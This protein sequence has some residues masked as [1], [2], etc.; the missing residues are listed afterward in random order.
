MF[1]EDSRRGF[2]TFFQKWPW[3]KIRPMGPWRSIKFIG[4]A[5]KNKIIDKT[6]SIASK[7]HKKQAT[8]ECSF[9]A[10]VNINIWE[11]SV[12]PW[13]SSVHNLQAEFCERK[14]YIPRF[15]YVKYQ[16]SVSRRRNETDLTSL[17]SSW[18]ELI[19]ALK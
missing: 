11:K 4:H 2:L 14:L 19:C 9:S 18:Y 17:F 15:F 13:M 8:Y 16:I 5:I 7:Y 12:K 1:K 6:A 10:K 3:K